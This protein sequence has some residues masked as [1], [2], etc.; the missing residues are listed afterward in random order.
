MPANF[1]EKTIESIRSRGFVSRHLL[2]YVVNVLCCEWCRYVIHFI[3][4]LH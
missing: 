2:N 1:D 4:F 3:V